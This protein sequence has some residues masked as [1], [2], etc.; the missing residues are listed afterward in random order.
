MTRA[1]LDRDGE[2]LVTQRGPL[3]LWDAVE[4]ALLAW[5][6]TDCPDRSGYGLTVTEGRQY[7]WL[8]A[9]GGPS[10]DPLA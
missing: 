5:Y 7:I 2:W 6:D 4:D 3:R 1:E 8:G 10:R 9:P